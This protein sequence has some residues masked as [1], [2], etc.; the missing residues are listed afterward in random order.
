M[1]SIIKKI[2]NILVK[3][4]LENPILKKKTN[5]LKS[6]KKI[7][8][9]IEKILI[10]LNLDSKNSNIID[11]PKRISSMLI[12]EIFSGLYYE[13]F[14]KISFI[15]NTI[16]VEEMIKIFNISFTSFCEHHFLIT[17]GK[18]F[19]AYF[20][21]RKILGISTVNKIVNFF[22]KRPQI[23]ER[24]TKQIAI[25]LQTLLQIEDVAVL[26]QAKHFC[27]QIRKMENQKNYVITSNFCGKFEKSYSIK[28]EFYK[29]INV[30]FY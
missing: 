27:A 19:I 23:Q 9:C 4:K 2:K 16:Q 21:N 25:C 26:I 13:N 22:A 7:Q 30:K 18:A 12:K 20:P 17:E 8:N 1:N 6:Q 10:Y 5:F 15:K 14:P 24:M 11:T 3:K 28:K 29:F